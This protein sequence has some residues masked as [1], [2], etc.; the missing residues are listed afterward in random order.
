MEAIC[1]KLNIP[2]TLAGAL[3]AA[4]GVHRELECLFYCCYTSYQV[5]RKDIHPWTNM[6]AKMILEIREE[7]DFSQGVRGK[8]F[9]AYRTGHIVQVRNSDGSVAEHHFTLEDGA[10]MIDPDLKARFPDS[11]SVNNALRS[12]VAH[13]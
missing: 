11:E 7:Y 12:L 13:Q 4:V 8:H 1:S 5:G 3:Q 2:V 6:K 10:V 9:S